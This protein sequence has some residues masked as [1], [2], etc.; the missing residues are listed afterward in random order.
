M[1]NFT[2]LEKKWGKWIGKQLHYYY[3]Q[4]HKVYN[5]LPPTKRE[6]NIWVVLNIHDTSIMSIIKDFIHRNIFTLL[7]SDDKALSFI[8]TPQEMLRIIQYVQNKYMY[9]LDFDATNIIVKFIYN[10]T[11]DLWEKENIY[12]TNSL[13]QIINL[14]KYR[15]AHRRKV[16]EFYLNKIPRF[17]ENIV[18]HIVQY[19]RHDN[20]SSTS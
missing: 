5:K 10:I 7:T 20:F 15:L 18:H 9:T 1:D 8:D 12:V 4:T 2:M 13:I 14:N 3:I 6:T 19:L 16:G 17:D 11:I